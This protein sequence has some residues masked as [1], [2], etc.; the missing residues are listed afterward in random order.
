MTGSRRRES[1]R[2]E[3]SMG[4]RLEVAGLGN[5]GWMLQVRGECSES[6]LE[7]KSGSET[8]H[9][10]PSGQQGQQPAG[11]QQRGS[12]RYT[13]DLEREVRFAKASR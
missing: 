12:G 2:E 10:R 7:S 9:R 5:P 13:R 8:P 3:S 11:G 4:N 1:R 6:R